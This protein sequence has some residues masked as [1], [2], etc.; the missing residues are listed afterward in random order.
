M[1]DDTISKMATPEIDTRIREIRQHLDGQGGA[2]TLL[3]KAVYVRLEAEMY[4]LYVEKEARLS[5][6]L[7]FPPR[8]GQMEREGCAA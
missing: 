5:A 4:D 6:G 2:M 8:V 7:P 3:E 1:C